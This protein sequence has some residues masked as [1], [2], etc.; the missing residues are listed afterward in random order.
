[1][2]ARVIKI[3]LY[4]G[5]LLVLLACGGIGTYIF[6]AQQ[7]K[8]YYTEQEMRKM[9]N[10][11]TQTPSLPANFYTAYEHLYPEHRNQTLLEMSVK[12]TWYLA[13]RQDEALIA[14]MR[15]NCILASA[16]MKNQVPSKFHSRAPY[17][18][19]HGLEKY[20]SE[21]KCM[22]YVYHQLHAEER[23]Q[24]W[25]KKSLEMLSVEECKALILKLRHPVNSAR[26]KVH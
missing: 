14:S 18:T 22:D 2:H 5:T 16:F 13:T 19:A 26:H 6:L 1:M 10:V 24:E 4:L 20:S 12:S 8:Q 21:S 25:F 9:A 17:I 11:V 23:A 15:C 3:G 7:W